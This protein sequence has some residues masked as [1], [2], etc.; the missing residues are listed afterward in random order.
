MVLTDNFTIEAPF[1]PRVPQVKNF[2]LLAHAYYRLDRSFYKSTT[3]GRVHVQ[4][5][6]LLSAIPRINSPGHYPVNLSEI[7]TI[8][9]CSNPLLYEDT[10]SKL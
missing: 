10:D 5:Y 2:V 1:A 9:Q 3:A 8:I 4:S 6:I 7:V